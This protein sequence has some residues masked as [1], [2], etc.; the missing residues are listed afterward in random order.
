MMHNQELDLRAIFAEN[1]DVQIPDWLGRSA[2]PKRFYIIMKHWEKLT[3]KIKDLAAPQNLKAL[4]P[5]LKQQT[6]HFPEILGFCEVRPE[7]LKMIKTALY[8][9]TFGCLEENQDERNVFRYHYALNTAFD[10]MVIPQSHK[11]H[12]PEFMT[13]S[14]QVEKALA[15]TIQN[16]FEIILDKMRGEEQNDHIDY[17]VYACAHFGSPESRYSRASKKA[18]NNAFKEYYCQLPPE[19]RAMIIQ[20]VFYIKNE[21]TKELID[22]LIRDARSQMAQASSHVC[23]SNKDRKLV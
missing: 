6:P 8:G 2:R 18:I 17:M 1:M 3:T 7:M 16:I 4:F 22:G 14:G 23:R 5:L 20:S 13:E 11:C 10:L 9:V 12:R 19:E 21:G 15:S